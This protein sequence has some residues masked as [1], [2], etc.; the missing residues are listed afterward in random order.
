MKRKKKLWLTL[1]A[2]LL[3]VALVTLPLPQPVAVALLHAVEQLG[4]ALDEKSES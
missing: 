4:E 1:A 3:P 2:V